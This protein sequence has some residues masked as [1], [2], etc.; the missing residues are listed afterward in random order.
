[1]NKW[2]GFSI[3]F[4]SFDLTLHTERNFVNFQQWWLQGPS[5]PRERARIVPLAIREEYFTARFIARL[6]PL[7][8]RHERCSSGWKRMDGKR[9]RGVRAERQRGRNDGKK[10]KKR[11]KERG[12]EGGNEVESNSKRH[13]KL[14]VSVGIQFRI[15]WISISLKRIDLSLGLLLFY[16]VSFFF[17][18][19]SSGPGNFCRTI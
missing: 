2:N 14:G 18:F 5:R 13:C 11:E 3:L 8:N 10:K 16:S 4:V 9:W 15:Q 6:H 7:I 19:D 12:G 17:L 1:M